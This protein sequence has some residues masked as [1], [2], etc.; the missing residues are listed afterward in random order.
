MGHNL[1]KSF[2]F[3]LSVLIPIIFGN[4]VGKIGLYFRIILFHLPA[5]QG[6]ES[7][8]YENVPKPC[9]LCHKDEL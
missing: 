3:F 4:R 8:Q 6:I 2:F 9:R 5:A 7:F 1:E